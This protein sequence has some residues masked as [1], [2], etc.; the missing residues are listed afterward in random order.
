MRN[1]ITI[2]PIHVQPIATPATN[3]MILPIS[4]LAAFS[5]GNF[6]SFAIGKVLGITGT[7]DII[8]SGVWI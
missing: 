7:K 8:D 5:R 3:I 4:T 2:I 6:V 1:S